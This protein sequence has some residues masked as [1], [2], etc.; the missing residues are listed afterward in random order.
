MNLFDRHYHAIHH[1]LCVSEQR[2]TKCIVESCCCISKSEQNTLLRM[3][4]LVLHC[5]R[6]LDMLHSFDAFLNMDAKYDMT[7][8]SF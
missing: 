8:Q 4:G 2:S 5:T 6:T 3:L 7:V 1:A